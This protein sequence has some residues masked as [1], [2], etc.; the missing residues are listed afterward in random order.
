ME[1]VVLDL[2]QFHFLELDLGE[3]AHVHGLVAVG[4]FHLEFASGHSGL[5]WGHVILIVFNIVNA[6][7]RIV[8]VA[9]GSNLGV[10]ASDLVE[11]H[12]YLAALSFI[13][14]RLLRRIILYHLLIF[15]PERVVL[16][17]VLAHQVLFLLEDLLGLTLVVEHQRLLIHHAGFWIVCFDLLLA[18]GVDLVEV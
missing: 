7:M 9:I 1:T 4:R 13:I 15:L 14:K 6:A 3:F 17:P 8:Y 10:I 18:Q 16:L 12:Y 2:G 11:V 5:Y